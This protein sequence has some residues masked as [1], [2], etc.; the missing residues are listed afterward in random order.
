[1][2]LR[3]QDDPEKRKPNINLA[4]KVLNWKPE[5]DLDSGLKKTIKYFKN[6]L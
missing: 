3:L 2:T 1:M 6:I 5:V 4:K